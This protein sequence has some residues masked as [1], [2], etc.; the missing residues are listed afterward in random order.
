[1]HGQ[2]NENL[3]EAA[4]GLQIPPTELKKKLEATSMSTTTSMPKI[5]RHFLINAAEI[6]T[7]PRST[8][9][10]GGKQ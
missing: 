9:T 6:L 8:S 10:I 1:M 5:L 2:T 4:R 7:I 3:E